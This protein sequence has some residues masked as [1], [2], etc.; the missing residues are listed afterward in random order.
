MPVIVPDHLCHVAVDTHSL[1]GFA[2]DFASAKVLAESSPSESAVFSVEEL[3]SDDSDESRI[4]SVR[5]EHNLCPGLSTNRLWSASDPQILLT[6]LDLAKRDGLS[7]TVGP[8]TT[9]PFMA[10]VGVESKVNSENPRFVGPSMVV[11]AWRCYI[12]HKMG[13]LIVVPTLP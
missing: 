4:L 13:G 8:W 1:E 7:M 10:H 5:V 12:Y 3:S 6:V 2:L 11:A 9:S